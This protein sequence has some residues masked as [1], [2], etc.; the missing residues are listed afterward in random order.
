MDHI[1][2]AFDSCKI[3]SPD[4]NHYLYSETLKLKTQLDSDKSVIKMLH[5]VRMTFNGN[6]CMSMED[7]FIALLSNKSVTERFIHKVENIE[8]INS[9]D[10]NNSSHKIKF[11]VPKIGDMMESIVCELKIKNIKVT[12]MMECLYDSF[13]DNILIREYCVNGENKKGLLIANYNIP[14]NALMHDTYVEIEFDKE[15]EENDV[16]IVYNILNEDNLSINYAVYEL[17]MQKGRFIVFSNGMVAQHYKN[18]KYDLVDHYNKNIPNQLTQLY[19]DAHEEAK[20]RI[21]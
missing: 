3:I 17:D 7:A 12:N 4:D 20:R 6:I 19:S 14:I 5:T 13:D 9:I 15:Y 2:S 21:L 11:K 8:K 10:E 18:D 16:E 1:L